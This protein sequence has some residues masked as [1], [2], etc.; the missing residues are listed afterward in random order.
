MP[1]I[2][3][4]N[5]ERFEKFVVA[6]AEPLFPG[7]FRIGHEAL[8]AVHRRLAV[9]GPQPARPAKWRDSTFDGHSRAR[10]RDRIPRRQNHSRAFAN[11][12]V[13]R[14]L[15]RLC[16][17]ESPLRRTLAPAGGAVASMGRSVAQPRFQL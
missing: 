13:A 5:R 16:H 2:G 15:A 4:G 7:F 3:P 17:R 14:S 11:L 9:L 6:L 12:L 10:E 8:K 1:R